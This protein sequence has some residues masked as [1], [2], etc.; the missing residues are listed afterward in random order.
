MRRKEGE[1]GEGRKKT[2]QRKWKEKIKQKG[3]QKKGAEETSLL[4]FLKLFWCI[5]IFG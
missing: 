5:A 2:K 1:R 3:Y 4:L